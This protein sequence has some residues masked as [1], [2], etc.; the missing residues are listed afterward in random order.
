M[1][2]PKVHEDVYDPTTDP[3]HKPAAELPAADP[4]VPKPKGPTEEE[5]PPG[6]ETPGGPPA[7]SNEPAES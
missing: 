7:P 2:E 1:D 3:R 5:R 4:N 6:T